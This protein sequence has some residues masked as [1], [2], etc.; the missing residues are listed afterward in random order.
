M[1]E[2]DKS[3]PAPLG[4]FRLMANELETLL[5]VEGTTSGPLSETARMFLLRQ[6]A[7]AWRLGQETMEQIHEALKEE[8][9]RKDRAISM[10]RTQLQG[11]LMTIQMQRRKD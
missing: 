1:D 6:Y 5:A 10:L 2:D 11:A 3:Q 9:A 7:Y 4:P 8:S